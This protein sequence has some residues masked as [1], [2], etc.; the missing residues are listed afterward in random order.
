MTMSVC[1]FAYVFSFFQSKSSKANE[2]LIVSAFI[3][4]PNR[5]AK[6]KAVGLGCALKCAS[7]ICGVHPPLRRH[8]NTGPDLMNRE[9]A[10]NCVGSE[11]AKSSGLEPIF[12]PTFA[13][14]HRPPLFLMNEY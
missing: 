4:R 13:F 5:W 11:D 2:K 10:R 9:E 1:P 3:W 8:K 12:G 14:A 7:S 6:W